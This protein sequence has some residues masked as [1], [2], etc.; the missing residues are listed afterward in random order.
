LKEEEIKELKNGIAAY[1]LTMDM[2][3]TAVNL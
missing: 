2:T 3:M 1:K